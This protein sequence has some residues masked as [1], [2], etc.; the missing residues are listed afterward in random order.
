MNLH[1]VVRITAI[2]L[3]DTTAI[4][5]EIFFHS[6]VPFLL[7]LFLTTIL[8]LIKSISF[9][10]LTLNRVPSANTANRF[11]S[12]QSND[13][14]Q[15]FG[16]GPQQFPGV[17]GFPAGGPA[18]FPGGF[19][20]QGY[21]Y[22]GQYPAGIGGKIID[23]NTRSQ[24]NKIYFKVP[25]AVIRSQITL[26]MEFSLALVAQPESLADLMAVAMLLVVM[27]DILVVPVSVE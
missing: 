3:M 20:G 26:L 2:T 18:Q 10:P 6:L 8:K 24:G 4:G 23:F 12:Q 17:G 16:L 14:P 5:K 13:F 25:K 22:P 7:S 11:G 27:A 9:M 21:P 19:G 15:Q 1:Q